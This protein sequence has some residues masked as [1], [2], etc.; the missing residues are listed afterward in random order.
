[1]VVSEFRRGRIW[2]GCM[3]LMRVTQTKV[4]FNWREMMIS[5]KE[6]LKELLALVNNYEDLLD[7]K[8]DNRDYIKDA[9]GVE[10]LYEEFGIRC[11]NSLAGSGYINLGEYDSIQRFFEGSNRSIGCSDDDRQPM[12]ETLYIVGF[13]CG[14][15][16]WNDNVGGHAM[17]KT[18]NAF[19]DELK[20]FGPKYSDSINKKLYFTS[21]KSKEVH[22]A[23]MPLFN[24]YRKMIV[25]EG[26]EIDRAMI[27]KRLELL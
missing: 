19:F 4:T 1:V 3:G 9:I 27:E 20:D 8:I 17:N 23:L 7:Y 18:F 26:L 12:D 24:K 21:E 13:P 5:K 15:L 6:R 10:E 25:K 2:R 22:E 14:S 16:S 11:D